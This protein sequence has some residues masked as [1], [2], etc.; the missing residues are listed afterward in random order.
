M[1]AVVLTAGQGTRLEPLT[2]SRSKAMIDFHGKPIL[3]RLLGNLSEIGFN[4]VAVVINP[5]HRKMKDKFRFTGPSSLPSITWIEQTQGN[6][7]GHGVMATQDYIDEQD[8]FLL[9]YGDIMFNG[10]M[11][12]SLLNSFHA[13]RKPLAVVSLTG[14]SRDFG[15]IY[16]DQ[17]MR[18]SEIIEKPKKKK[19]GNY[20]LAGAFILPGKM[21][22]TL[23]R[24]N[25]SMINALKQ[26]VT[27]SELYASI[28]EDEWIDIAYPWSILSANQMF[29]RVWKQSI[30][31]SSI[32]I[33]S[34]V[35]I[36]GPVHIED[37]VIIKAGANI[38][39]PCF[40]G[41]DSFIGHT[42]LLRECTSIGAGSTIGFG[43]E[44]KNSVIMPGTEIGRLSFIGDSVIG[45]NVEIGSA[46]IMVN[47]RMDHST[48][49]VD[50]GGKLID[51]GLKK[52]G[53]FIG[54]NAWIGANHTFLPGTK[55]PAG[56]VIPHFD[57]YPRNS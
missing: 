29:M 14:D 19:M 9:S 51:S 15:I 23:A 56:K 1:K 26:L 24:F 54:D 57:T 4:D 53:S 34:G 37:N 33:E 7:I 25:G 31:S 40:I 18:I 44:I 30:H 48:V 36:S 38:I 28:W 52:L 32:K 39:G 43:V 16:M 17:E 45:E 46:T 35:N 20:I 11:L 50:I 2:D 3:A 21:I 41:R 5:K 55:I 6:D 10:N 13:I 47:V 49:K 22:S 27:Q 12:R 42:A 8:Y